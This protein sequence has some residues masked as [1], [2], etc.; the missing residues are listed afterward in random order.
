MDDHVVHFS[1][2]SFDDFSTVRLLTSSGLVPAV[3]SPP[4]S[5]F[6]RNDD[7]SSLFQEHR[8][9]H[10]TEDEGQKVIERRL[11]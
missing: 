3:P 9:D 4:T 2:P 7:P 5:H 11:L 6:L 8:G 1:F 10:S